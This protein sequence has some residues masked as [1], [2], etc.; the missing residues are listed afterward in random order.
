MKILNKL[1]DEEVEMLMIASKNGV[2]ESAIER[3]FKDKTKECPICTA[4]VRE[5][6]LTLHFEE[7]NLRKK[8]S[9]CGNDCLKYFLENYTKTEIFEY[10]KKSNKNI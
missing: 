10:S 1:T 9:F 8:A 6:R 5:G 4:P 7:G 3:R 2:L